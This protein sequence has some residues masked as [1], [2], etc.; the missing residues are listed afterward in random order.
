MKI[1]VLA[2]IMSLL[3]LCTCFVACNEEEEVV[4]DDTTTEAPET[5]DTEAPDT[6][7]ED[8]EKTPGGE[9]PGGETPGGETPTQTPEEKYADLYAQGYTYYATKAGIITDAEAKYIL[10][11]DNFKKW[12]D[13]QL[14]GTGFNGQY[15]LATDVTI[16]E[17][18]A[19][20]WANTKPSIVFKPEA[21]A[22]GFSG[23]FDGNGKTISGVCITP[24]TT[25]GDEAH[26]SLFGDLNGGEIK[27][28]RLVNTY[29]ESKAATA[30]NPVGSFAARMQG[31]NAKI[32]N[33]YSE[34]IIKCNT[35]YAGGIAGGHVNCTA[36]PFPV[37]ENCVFAGKI[38]GNGAIGGIVGGTNNGTLYAKNCINLGTLVAAANQKTVGGIVGDAA[39]SWT[40]T[41]V[42]NCV[43]LSKNVP[44]ALAGEG[45]AER[46][47][48]GLNIT[49]FVMI[50]DI[51]VSS[52]LSEN[53][54]AKAVGTANI[55]NKTLAEFLDANN[56]VF[57]DWTYE[58][59]Y[60]PNP[61]THTKIPTSA[62]STVP[63]N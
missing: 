51:G 45:V 63:A 24:G 9:T 15:I 34:A 58:A 13:I 50:T 25:S 61:T 62:V 48:Q 20:D 17:G 47:A 3:L 12:Y 5:T 11:Q 31:A 54:A 43:N 4:T 7:K 6:E 14:M 42:E 36:E 60:I 28:L 23:K 37:I 29:I 41:F 21:A 56:K 57:A 39:Y 52:A 44:N 16:N 59:G 19:A 18:N 35:A 30:T 2:L 32:S 55:T 38:E 8:D 49:S 33:C 27:N 53:S 46:Y 22:W 10:D 26:I 40:K 1:K